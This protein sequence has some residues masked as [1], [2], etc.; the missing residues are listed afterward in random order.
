[1]QRIDE[2]TEEV[3]EQVVKNK[4]NFVWKII[5]S[6]GMLYEMRIVLTSVFGTIK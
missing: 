5:S 6:P 1:M 4:D 3:M 2:V